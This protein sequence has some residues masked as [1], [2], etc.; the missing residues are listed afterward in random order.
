MT[1]GPIPNAPTVLA[2]F[3]WDGEN[4]QLSITP[5]GGST[6]SYLRDFMC[7]FKPGDI[8]KWKPIG[9]EEYDHTVAEVDAGRWQPRIAPVTFSLEEFAKDID[10][11]NAR[12]MEALNGH[13]CPQTRPVDHGSR[14]WPPGILSH[15]HSHFRRDGHAVFGCGQPAGGQ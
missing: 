13:Y 6:T 3:T 10:G 2:T 5:N 14:P 9:R 15:R 12:V 4:R 1:S 7:L 8:V 11:T